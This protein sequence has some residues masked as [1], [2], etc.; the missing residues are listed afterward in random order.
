MAIENYLTFNG[1][2]TSDY[3]VYISGEGIFNAPERAVEMISIPGRSGAL[4]LDKGYFENIEVVY[5]AFVVCDDLTSMETALNGLRNAL[6]AQKGY[7]RLSDTFH[8]NE[9][10]MALFKD[11]LEVDVVK[12]NTAGQFD[13]VF[14]C[15][16]QRYLTSGDTEQ[17]IMSGTTLTNPSRFDA[18][19]MF[20]A[21][22]SGKIH[23]NGHT[24]NLR[25]AALGKVV[26]NE[27]SQNLGATF[28]IPINH[29]LHNTSDNLI[30]EG[31]KFQ[32]TLLGYN[33]W[34]FQVSQTD[35]LSGATTSSTRFNYD[36]GLPPDDSKCGRTFETA[37]SD[38]TINLSAN[39]TTTNTAVTTFTDPGLQN[40]GTVTA[41][42]TVA[43]T[44]GTTEG[45]L[46]ISCNFT[47][48]APGMGINE[49][50]LQSQ[51]IA[52]GQAYIN[53]TISTSANSAYIDCDTGDA[54]MNRSGEYI[55][56][57][58]MVDFGTDLPY[59]SP[60]SNT[61]TFDSTITS[62]KIKPRWWTL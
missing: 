39:A 13:L 14:N 56:L 46:T 58:S 45:T 7:V 59:L 32:W 12:Y 38:R 4:A 24:I 62:L 49:D 61:I 33:T 47:Y 60:G 29:N 19:P 57:N 43:Y 23:F 2:N 40:T 22:G 15:K 25:S 1:I 31:L 18:S 26:L 36:T 3:G 54:Y 20:I 37:W 50:K 35:S 27:N 10:R 48:N 16:P 51:Y 55:S 5:P 52:I 9:F 6:C 28:S 41:T 11:G 21:S 44:K 34:F 30:I 17:T 53:S 8:P 42:Q